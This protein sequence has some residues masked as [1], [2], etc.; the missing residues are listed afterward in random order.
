MAEGVDVGA[1]EEWTSVEEAGGG[2]EVKSCLPHS[3]PK[4]KEMLT[5]SRGNKLVGSAAP[6]G[7]Q[8]TGRRG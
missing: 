7:A 5:V 2:A 8:H 6:Q 1:V 4:Q 3:S